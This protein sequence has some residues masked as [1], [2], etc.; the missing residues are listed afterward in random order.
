M[1]ARDYLKLKIKRIVNKVTSHLS[2]I[3][4]PEPL[5][6]NID[7]LIH[8][9]Y[10]IL[11]NRK[12]DKKGFQHY[13][14]LLR[15]GEISPRAFVESLMT[16]D[17]FRNKFY[18]EN[19]LVSLHYSRCQFIKMLPEASKILDLGG[20]SHH[21]ERGALVN[22]G[23]PYK[24]EE[25]VIVDLPSEEDQGVSG[26]R[27]QLDI[28]RTELGSVRY[29]YHSMTDLSSYAD[30]SFDMVMSGQSIEHLDEKQGD[31]MIQEIFR[32]LRPGG[33]F[34]LDTPNGVACRLQQEDFINVNHK[35]EYTHE[36]LS[37]KLKRAGFEI[38]EA[39]GLNYMGESFQKGEFSHQEVAKNIGIYENIK[40]CYLLAYICQK[41]HL[42]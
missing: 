19:H 42:K 24:F 15:S 31:Q 21:D 40:N 10:K 37:K 2:A 12:P 27:K 22:M 5:S 20:A 23:Y 7:N 8:A 28:V 14:E 30:E 6:K 35:I 9:G 41:P 39:K 17:E 13:Q 1:S 32:V 25:L 38:R 16:S 26:Q 33:Y 4:F 3:N 18:F 11:L 29:Q 36:Q 34:C